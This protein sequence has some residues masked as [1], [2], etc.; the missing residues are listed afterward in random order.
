MCKV[1]WFIKER[2]NTVLFDCYTVLFQGLAYIITRFLK[3]ESEYLKIINLL[4]T[5]Y[6]LSV[7]PVIRFIKQRSNM[8]VSIEFY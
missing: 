4:S 8:V 5:I 3:N 1:I 7:Y 2:S 6:N